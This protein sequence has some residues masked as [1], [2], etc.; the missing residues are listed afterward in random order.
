MKTMP[1][2]LKNLLNGMLAPLTFWK[3]DE[4]LMQ[5]V[6]N[7]K[8]FAY[9][10]IRNKEIRD[11]GIDGRI[12]NRLSYIGTHAPSLVSIRDKCKL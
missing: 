3:S 8:F 9:I 5:D 11:L 6:D 4:L 10:N 1:A 7:E 12:E 2:V